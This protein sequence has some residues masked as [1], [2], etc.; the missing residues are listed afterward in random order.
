VHTDSN[1]AWVEVWIDGRWRYLGACE[2]EPELDIAWFT[3]PATRAMMM[4][5]TVPGK[6]RG[7]EETV[8]RTGLYT[9]LNLLET[10]A[11]SRK[12][13]VT[14]IDGDGN[15][16]RDADV[17]FKVYNYSEFYP[18][19]ARKSDENGIANITTGFGDLLIWVSNDRGYG[20]GKL[21]ADR[22]EIAVTLHPFEGAQYWENLLMDV[23]P[24][25]PVS[26]PAA[27]KAAEN[28]LHLARE[29]SIRNAFMSTFPDRDYAASLAAETGLD[30][31]AVW[32]YLNESQGNWMEI[33]SF[34]REY[35]DRPYLF[36]FLGSLTSKD[37][38]DTP[39]DHLSDHMPR[40]NSINSDLPVETLACDI[41]SPKI[42]MEI[43]TPWRSY[44]GCEVIDK[45]PGMKEDPHRIVEY[46]KENIRI[47]ADQNYVACLITPRGVHETRMADPRSRNVYFVALCRTAGIP[48]RIERATGKPQFL[49][50]GQWY[51]AVFGMES[52]VTS[53][54]PTGNIILK[55]AESNRIV[56]AYR[57]HYTLARYSDGDFAT[58][59]LA[60]KLTGA[61]YPIEIEVPAGYYRL[62]T[63][64]RANDGSVAVVTEY[65]DLLPDLSKEITVSLPELED[66]LFVEGI[67][68]MNTVVF[69]VDGTKT[70]LKELSRGKGLA[71]VFAD[72]V[73]EPTRHILQELP[74]RRKEFEEWGGGIIF[75][76]TA[77]VAG[78]T[79]NGSIFPGMPS[80][81]ITLGDAGNSLLN[82]AV[83]S[84]R[85]EF[86]NEYPLV[87]YLNTSGGILFS[88]KGY[89]IGT[90]ERLWQTITAERRTL[91]R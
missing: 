80:G 39:R 63:G 19:A 57:S 72:P 42:D 66:K 27:D 58:L 91:E 75:V 62:T 40:Q 67:L 53:V 11:P 10:Y 85:I 18:I 65:F 83:E 36:A 15:A 17:R 14:V 35:K 5:T 7:P 30:P 2:P 6:Y 1:H 21:P 22:N 32:K 71:V 49:A 84:L 25:G 12:V 61:A 78:S 77:D 29:D 90:V 81:T 82:A 79:L 89:R 88:S 8:N 13:A 43:I 44:L 64:S 69:L 20:Y 26:A 33:E 50:N 59:D 28:R 9:V 70:T 86:S 38:R 68:D 51:D 23:P 55:C 3:A 87:L 37:L 74:A 54:Q 31:E 48:A 34:M 16:I 47:A 46:V 76:H 24:E 52:R 60:G 45:F 56:P 73:S 4:H 41:L